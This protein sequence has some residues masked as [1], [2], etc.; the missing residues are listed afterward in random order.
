MLSVKG[1]DISLQKCFDFELDLLLHIKTGQYTFLST[2]R[3][4]PWRIT[5]TTQQDTKLFEEQI[6]K[7]KTIHRIL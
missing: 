5:S 4:Q 6:N 1:K 7:A 3:L 2:A